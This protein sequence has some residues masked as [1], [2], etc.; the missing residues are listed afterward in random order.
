M[1]AIND[2]Y[3]KLSS[4]VKKL[5][6]E[7]TKKAVGCEYLTRIYKGSIILFSP[8]IQKPD[9]MLLGIN[10]GDGYFDECG[11]NIESFHPHSKLQYLDYD[12]QL[13]SETKSVFKSAGLCD[14]LKNSAVKS[15]IFF[16]ATDSEK[17]LKYLKYELKASYEIDLDEISRTWTLELIDI[18][19]PKTILC[20]GISAFKY[21]TKF[22]SGKEV[23]TNGKSV[24]ESTINDIHIIGYSRIYSKIKDKKELSTLLKKKFDIPTGTSL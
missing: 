20:E 11:E 22:M 9:I 4:D 5:H 2:R 8:L 15:N 12:Y 13:A 24:F 19:K 6:Q 23:R 18:V 7:I 10:S 3:S 16:Q 21:L 14:M 17:T 1:N